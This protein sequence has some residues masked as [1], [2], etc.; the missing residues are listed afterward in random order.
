MIY[1]HIKMKD[2]L[3][4][5]DRMMMPDQSWLTAY[6]DLQYLLFQAGQ[7]I[8]MPEETPESRKQWNQ[9]A[10]GT[11]LNILAAAELSEDSFIQTEGEFGKCLLCELEEL[12]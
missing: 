1:S 5:A 12:S 11:L 8:V 3:R 6:N 2:V 4:L 10:P 7:I 9:E